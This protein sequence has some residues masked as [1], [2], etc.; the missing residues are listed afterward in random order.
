MS[1]YIHCSLIHKS[2]A[3]ELPD[4]TDGPL[5]GGVDVRHGPSL[6]HREEWNVAVCDSTDGPR[7]E[8][9]KPSVSQRKTNTKDFTWCGI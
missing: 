2:H 4:A 8:Y 7:G 6:S 3:V 5:E 9:T 1:P